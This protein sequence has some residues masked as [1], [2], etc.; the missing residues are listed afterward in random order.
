[1]I[2]DYGRGDVIEE[3][4]ILN[5]DFDFDFD[6]SL[7]NDDE[8][9]FADLF[10]YS[11]SSSCYDNHNES[12]F[13]SLFRDI[14]DKLLNND[15]KE[16]Q[17]DENTTTTDVDEFFS[18]LQLPS[19]FVHQHHPHS[20]SQSQD[21]QEISMDDLLVDDD[22]PPPSPGLNT[23]YSPSN[24]S[25]NQVVTILETPDPQT[26]TPESQVSFQ[27]DDHDHQEKASLEKETTI[28][29]T[30]SASLED[31]EDDDPN[32]KKRKRQMRNRDAAVRSR[33]RKK[34][35]VKDLEVKS[36]YL[37][38]EC[39]R[40][41]RLLQCCAAEN[42]ALH[43]QLQEKAFSASRTKQESAVLFLGMNPG[44]LYCHCFIIIFRLQ[45]RFSPSVMLLL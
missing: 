2:G 27:D 34:M 18:D 38:A 39:I 21:D 1:M 3:S 33:E 20:H 15:E 44:I 29:T 4:D 43:F 40:L 36:K 31:K 17:R 28:T 13:S 8:D 26:S 35:Y 12:S 41:Q 24:S 32:T 37:E 19:Y 42:H 5:H 7:F 14:E 30:D 22:V 23:N 10:P 25:S 16:Y 6:F 45:F 11:S 9:L